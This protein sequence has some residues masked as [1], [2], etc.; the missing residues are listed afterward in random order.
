MTQELIKSLYTAYFRAKKDNSIQYIV[1]ANSSY[2]I[3]KYL[4]STINSDIYF[5]I[6]KKGLIIK[7]DNE[8]IYNLNTIEKLNLNDNI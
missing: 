6:N 5:S 4:Y 7:Y 1:P 2:S 3:S 8:K